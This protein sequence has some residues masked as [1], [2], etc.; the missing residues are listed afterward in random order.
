MAN[1]ITN[2]R[3]WDDADGKTW[4]RSVMDMDYQILMVSQFTLLAKTS[5]GNKPDFHG[6]CSPEK[7]KEMYQSLVE[8][9]REVYVTEKRVDKDAGMKLVQDGV[10]QAM[11]Q[12]ALVNDGPVTLE[13]NTPTKQQ[14]TV[15]Q[16]KTKKTPKP[17]AP[18]NGTEKASLTR[19]ITTK[20]EDVA[21]L[22][23]E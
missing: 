6:A 11:M 4:K 18:R 17:K 14:P 8:K 22:K 5:K 10:F 7:A 3:V 9:T 16:Q 15:N 12:V 20:I 1:R 2:L 23:P 13:I 19:E 21:I